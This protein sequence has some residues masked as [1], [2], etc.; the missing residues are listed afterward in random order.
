MGFP[1]GMQLATV[2]FGIPLTATGK[3]VLTKVRVRPTS[4]VIW[5]A[6]GQPLPEFEDSFMAEAGQLGQFQ[7]PFVDQPGFIDSAGNAVTD[8]AYRIDASWEFGNERPIKWEK[9]L[10]PLLG[11]TGPIDLD[12]VPDGPVSIPVTAPT[13][14]VL[15]FNGRTGFI[16]L[17]DADLPA[18]LSAEELSATYAT[19]AAVGAKLDKTE[20]ATTYANALKVAPSPGRK[21]AFAGDSHTAGSGVST[22][23]RRFSVVAPQ[24]SGTRWF[25]RN[26]LQAGVAGNTSAQLLARIAA[27]ALADTAV[28]H[29]HVQIGTN[30]AGTGVTPATFSANIKEIHA[31]VQGSGRSMSIGLVPPRTQA[32]G[33]A[34]S[35]RLETAY[36]E[37]I[38]SWAGPAAVTVADTRTPLVDPATGYLAAAY[39]AD[40]IH[41]NDAGH[42]LIAKA[43]ATAL[44]GVT[45]RTPGS[46]IVNPDV[47][48]FSN[49]T[50][51]GGTTTTAPTGWFKHPNS[52][53]TAPVIGTVGDTSS[54]LAEGSWLQIDL[55]AA[56]A[57]N[58]ILLGPQITTS[59][60]FAENDQIVT[61]FQL[62]ID[63][64][65]GYKAAYLAG[66]ANLNVKLVNQ[67][68]V[69]LGGQP[70]LENIGT[71]NPGPVRFAALTP[72]AEGATAINIM[73]TLTAPAGVQVRVRIG[74]VS[75]RN[76]TAEGAINIAS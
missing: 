22:S 16:T 29:V 55:N 9:N 31:L 41:F 24:L 40:G 20:A 50:M 42:L 14:S 6:T 36:N 19:S 53:G 15:G 68:M 34:T 65:S 71:E 70:M 73:V 47:N 12:L 30:D 10:K 4:R 67:S 11:Q 60:N 75:F 28:Q 26:P 46:R 74:A 48:K 8:W 64:V 37:W 52:T 33:T 54:A 27:D 25:S 3:E 58:V 76:A 63:D 13:A 59:G 49:G 72:S 23:N 32:S 2:A 62:Q 44:L 61:E 1:A 18:R 35:R 57:S 45:E 38:T 69:Q 56:E 43:I 39:S 21:I 17:T 66:T 51:T 5:A 7:V